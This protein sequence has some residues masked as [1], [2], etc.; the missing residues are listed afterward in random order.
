M[1]DPLSHKMPPF[2]EIRR[3]GYFCLARPSQKGHIVHRRANKYERARGCGSKNSHEQ[4]E[5]LSK[6][7]TSNGYHFAFFTDFPCPVREIHVESGSRNRK[8]GIKVEPPPPKRENDVWLQFFCVPLLQTNTLIRFS[9]KN[10]SFIILGR[11]NR[12]K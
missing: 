7:A 11:S 10:T 8:S 1:V 9:A 6:S 5:Y 3:K 2:S 4:S 12:A